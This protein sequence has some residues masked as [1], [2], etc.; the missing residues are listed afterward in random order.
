MRKLK[1]YGEKK[2]FGPFKK[3]GF[4]AE[5]FVI[6]GEVIVKSKNESVKRE[7]QEK[8][9]KRIREDLIILTKGIREKFPDGRKLYYS[10]MERKKPED[11][12]FLDA[13]RDASAFWSVNTFGG[14]KISG[15]L[16]KFVEE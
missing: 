1:L 16:S 3:R 12:E 8:I 2:I 9:N 14:Y 6:N 7:L 13:I 4:I 5:V 11:P 15:V 10:I